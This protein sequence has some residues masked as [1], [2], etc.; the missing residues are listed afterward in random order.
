MGFINKGVSDV[1]FESVQDRKM[2]YY[3][4]VENPSPS[5]AASFYSPCLNRPLTADA[6]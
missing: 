5:F 6:S 2:K 4:T 1:I 3:G